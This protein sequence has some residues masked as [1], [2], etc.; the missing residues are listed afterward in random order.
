MDLK[1]IIRGVNYY[2]QDIEAIV[3]EASPLIRKGC[4]AAFS[5]DMEGEVLVVVAEVRDPKKLP[6]AGE[7]SDAFWWADPTQHCV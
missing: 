5:V 4:T 6:D 1:I 2:P 3:E 7:R